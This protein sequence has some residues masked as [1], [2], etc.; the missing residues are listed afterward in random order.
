MEK[1]EAAIDYETG[2]RT[3]RIHRQQ[4]RALSNVMDDMQY[5]EDQLIDQLDVLWKRL[6]MEEQQHYGHP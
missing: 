4:Q 6:T 3:L 2:L 1:R 5:V